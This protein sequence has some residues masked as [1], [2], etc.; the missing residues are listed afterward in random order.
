MRREDEETPAKQNQEQTFVPAAQQLSRL[1]KLSAFEQ[2]AGC[3]VLASLFLNFVRPQDLPGLTFVGSIRLPGLMS[4][5]VIIVWLAKMNQG[6]TKP[7]K[8]MAVLLVFEGL[9]GIVG[10]Y[11][12]PGDVIVRNDYWQFQTWRDLLAQFLGLAFPIAVFF[13]RRIMINRLVASFNFIVFVLGLYAITHA[14][15]G[16]GGFLEDENDLCLVLVMFLP[17]AILSISRAVSSAGRIAGM[18]AAVLAFAGI[19]ATLSRGGFLG[20]VA[21][22]AYLLLSS[23][24]KMLAAGVMIVCAIAVMPLVSSRYWMEVESIQS[25]VSGGTGTVQ[26]RIDMWKVAYAMWSDPR[27]IV[28]GVGLGNT[29]YWFRDYEPRERLL[30]ERSLAGRAVHS[31]YFQLLPEMGLFGIFIVGNVIIGTLMLNRRAAG[32]ARLLGETA[33]S[34]VRELRLLSSGEAGSTADA[35]RQLEIAAVASPAE[36]EAI[37]WMLHVLQKEAALVESDLRMMNAA[38]LGVLTAGIGISVLYYPP[39]WVLAGT[40][41]AMQNYWRALLYAARP[42]IVSFGASPQSA[43]ELRV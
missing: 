23:R 5:L 21:V 22:L 7:T 40:S 1:F 14:G 13:S 11:L 41:A 16:P 10:K 39:L 25:D 8:Y 29:P 33:Q 4:V 42:L 19:V 2:C 15:R 36:R 27:H 32:K 35:R 30:R 28:F 12:D 3:L 6:W 18:V 43:G 26:Q 38:M 31:L 34:A 9:R 24:R 17:V 20:L 37:S